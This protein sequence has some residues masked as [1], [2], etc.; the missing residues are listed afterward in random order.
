MDLLPPPSPRP[1]GCHFETPQ[2]ISSG[3]ASRIPFRCSGIALRVEALV[4]MAQDLLRRPPW[5]DCLGSRRDGGLQANAADQALLTLDAALQL[6]DPA[7]ERLGTRWAAGDV[8][9]DRKDLVDPVD[10]GVAPCEDATRHGAVAHGDEVLRLGHLPVE[11]HHRGCHLL[12]Q[13]ARDDHDVGLTWRGTDHLRA[14]ARDVEF[15]RGHR[16]EFD[17]AAGEPEA[18][19]PEAVA[20]CPVEKRVDGADEYVRSGPEAV[21]ADRVCCRFGLGF[22]HRRAHIWSLHRLLY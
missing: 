1:L 21:V 16:Y 18:E 13:R 7:N 2:A 22:L 3:S 4:Q 5:V 17:K 9:V 12:R 10:L 11:A 14:E 6:H 15:G 8:D 20:P 19:R